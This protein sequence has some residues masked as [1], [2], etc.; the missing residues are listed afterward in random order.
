LNKTK[1]GQ[2]TEIDVILLNTVLLKYF[3]IKFCLKYGLKLLQ[4]VLCTIKAFALDS[5]FLLFS[6][7]L[8]SCS[9]SQL[10]FYIYPYFL[11]RT[12]CLKAVLLN[13]YP[14]Y[15]RTCTVL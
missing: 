14:N 6:Y 1:D 4:N 15:F 5:P 9:V 8:R 10:L 7:M 13:I 3:G 11:L 2:Q 12:T